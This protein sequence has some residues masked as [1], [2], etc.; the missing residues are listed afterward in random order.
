MGGVFVE[1]KSAEGGTFLGVHNLSE[2]IAQGI[3]PLSLF[4]GQKAGA[5]E[6]ATL[7][8]SHE[9]LVLALGG[10]KGRLF[11]RSVDGGEKF[12]RHR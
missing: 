5:G 8:V 7:N 12:F 9:F 2:G 10:A 3:E 6:K 11:M 1:V 4:Q